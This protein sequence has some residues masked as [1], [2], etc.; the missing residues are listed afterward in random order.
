MIHFRIFG[1][2]QVKP[3]AVGRSLAKDDRLDGKFDGI[4][5]SRAHGIR[6]RA[7]INRAI[8]N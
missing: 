7:G 4:E 2:G 6:K 3:S 8:D 1:E 5:R